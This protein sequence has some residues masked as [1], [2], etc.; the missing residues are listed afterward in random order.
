MGVNH[1]TI[2][3]PYFGRLSP[4][5]DQCIRIAGDCLRDAGLDAGE[6]DRA[7]EAIALGLREASHGLPC[8]R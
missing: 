6:A 5:A 2:L 8:Y 3:L 1:A 7:A 4:L